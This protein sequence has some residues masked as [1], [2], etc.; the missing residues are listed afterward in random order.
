MNTKDHALDLALDSAVPSILSPG[1]VMIRD[2]DFAAI[3]QALAAPNVASP[4]VQEP[5]MYED[6][7]DSKS[8]GHCGMVNG[9]RP[10]CRHNYKPPA[11]QRPVAEPHKWVGLTDEE[12][13]AAIKSN[14][15]KM[16]GGPLVL[17]RMYVRAIEAK[18]K[19]KNQ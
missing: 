19:E 3:K 8:C 6:W 16:K 18:L 10:E 13:D 7:Y 5:K 2:K 15:G 17:N 14:W 12:V 11:A 1:W 4:R 9:H